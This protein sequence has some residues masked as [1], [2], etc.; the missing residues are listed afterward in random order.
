MATALETNLLEAHPR[1]AGN[2]NSARRVRRDGK[3]PGVVYGAGGDSLP[4]TVDPRQVL[5]ILHSET[6]HNTIFDLALNAGERT[7][8]MIVDWQYEPIKGALLHIDV[9]RIA[10]DKA[11]K[12]SVPI[13]LKG[14]A[15]G[16]K[17]QGGILE[18]ITREVEIECLP[19]DIPSHI[20]ADVTHLVF[21]TV[22]RVA[23]LPHNPKL[24]FLSDPNQPVA[25]IISVK[26]EVAPTPEAVAA[27]AAAA[28]AEPE[29]IK[30]GKQETEEEGAEAP[31]EKPEKAEKEKKEKK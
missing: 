17:T 30:K 6:G 27:E 13:L 4:V 21:G 24:K 20:D 25:H 11:L 10:M 16:V 29:V 18:Q 3:I 23:D 5:R 14:D 31:A 15:E 7:K 28:P 1:E 9:K 19:T 22:L 12:V 26:E 2:K 8:A